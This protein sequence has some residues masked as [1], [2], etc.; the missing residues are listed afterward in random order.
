MFTKVGSVW[1][2]A[3]DER[4]REQRNAGGGVSPSFIRFRFEMSHLTFDWSTCWL[5]SLCCYH[6]VLG[7]GTCEGGGTWK[8]LPLCLVRG[9]LTNDV[10][11]FNWFFYYHL[12]RSWIGHLCRR[13]R[14]RRIV[15]WDLVEYH[16]HHHHSQARDGGD[17]GG[18]RDRYCCVARR[19]RARLP[20]DLFNAQAANND[21]HS[22]PF[23][24]RQR[25]FNRHL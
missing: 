23:A 21:Q 22:H 18:L 7:S 19:Q 8:T 1:V 2:R 13:R 25:Y 16:R 20:G 11:N 3:R 6:S 15:Q 9:P 10:T 14:W 17:F 5:D 24:N 4:W 12:A